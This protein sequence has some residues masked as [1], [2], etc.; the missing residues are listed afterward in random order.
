MFDWIVLLRLVALSFAL[1]FALVFS[2]TIR[3]VVA[4]KQLIREAGIV[5][6]LIALFVWLMGWLG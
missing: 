5:A 1:A 4:D 6:P 3:G 2:A